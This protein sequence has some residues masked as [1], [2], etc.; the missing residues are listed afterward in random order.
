MSSLRDA[1]GSILSGV[2]T[3]VARAA[4]VVGW[5][6]RSTWLSESSRIYD[7]KPVKVFTGSQTIL[8]VK[9]DGTQD[10]LAT[11]NATTTEVSLVP[12][13]PYHIFV[14]GSTVA[15]DSSTYTE[16]RFR[17]LKIHYD[18]RATT[19][20]VG[21]FLLGY[22]ADGA[23]QSSDVASNQAYFYS[24]NGSVSVPI[25]AGGPLTDFSPSLDSEWHYV[26][27]DINTDASLRQSYQGGIAAIW[28]TIPADGYWGYLVADF[29]LEL[30]QNRPNI[31]IALMRKKRLALQLGNCFECGSHIED[32][33]ER[34]IPDKEKKTKDVGS[35]F[36][37]P[38]L[39]VSI[40]GADVV[41]VKI[42]PGDDPLPV[43]V[44]TYPLYVTGPVVLAGV[45]DDIETPLPVAVHG[46]ASV[47]LVGQDYG[48]GIGDP[49]P[50]RVQGGGVFGFD[51]I[52]AKVNNELEANALA[53]KIYNDVE[54]PVAIQP[55]SNDSWDGYRLS[56][57]GD[58]LAGSS[59]PVL[60]LNSGASEAVPVD[61][62]P[63]PSRSSASSLSS[64]PVLVSSDDPPSIMPV[65]RREAKQLGGSSVRPLKGPAKPGKAPK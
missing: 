55:C 28:D 63:A 41:D 25:W 32:K 48:D 44:K 49:E 46:S 47:V 18:S 39:L 31:N 12:L 29:E 3:K 37:P 22:F 38:P 56:V 9:R 53:V 35:G 45:N 20:T 65:L 50:L 34:K 43:D 59:V 10:A 51:P 16:F 33:V 40:A 6:P 58:P 2:S 13:H 52:Q 14:N 23:M 4:G 60:V 36:D 5:A 19:A 15:N 26:D 21:S 8:I 62:A 54:H 7:G 64:S 17:K 42:I 11:L 57:A 24:L 27:E 30:R 1:A 61:V